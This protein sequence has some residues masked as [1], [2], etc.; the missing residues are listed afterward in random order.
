VTLTDRDKRELYNWSFQA[1]V[2]TLEPGQSVTF[3]TRMSSPPP[4]AKHLQLHL[5]ERGE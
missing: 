4:G 5:A 2:A 1:S 3:L